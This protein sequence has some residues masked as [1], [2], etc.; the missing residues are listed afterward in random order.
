MTRSLARLK[1]P[2]RLLKMITRFL[3]GQLGLTHAAI[4][5]R[6]PA[7]SHYTIFDSRGVRKL[8]RSLLKFDSEHRLIRWFQPEKKN[9]EPLRNWLSSGGIQVSLRNGGSEEL[10]KLQRILSDLRADIAVPGYYKKTLVAVLLLGEKLSRRLLAETEIHFFQ[11]LIHD[12]AIAVK[13]SEDHR[14]IESLCNK[15]EET[16]YQIMKSL[17]QEIH[18]KDPYTFSHIHQVEQLGLMTARELGLALDSKRKA[19]LSAG[20]LL[21]DVGKIGIPDSILKKPGPLDSDEWKIMRSHVE[22][23]VK[24]LEPLS[25]FKEAREIVH[26]HHENYDGS[27]YPRGL[28]GDQIPIEARIVSVVDAFH[29]IIS[30]RC[31]RKGRP[32]EAAIQEL[33]RCAPGQFD[34]GVVGAFI[35]AM[36]KNRT[37][38]EAMV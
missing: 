4:L 9:G 29:A 3:S 33:R 24:I 31:Y 19:A 20:L 25:D 17:A 30:T 21:H 5:V 34:P 6:N 22:R 37:P 15:E 8:P 13:T 1:R 16:Y 28:K 35:Q 11:T 14:R 26:C 23:G 18:A 7:K 32:V 12:V 10:R 36:K 2:E 27:G 38:L